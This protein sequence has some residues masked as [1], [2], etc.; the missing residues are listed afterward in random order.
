VTITFDALSPGVLN[1]QYPN[2]V[3]NWGG[4]TWIISGPWGSFT[5]NSL[6]FANAGIFSGSFSF[7]NQ[8][9]LVSIDAYNDDATPAT[10]TL[11]CLGQPNNQVTLDGGQLLTITIGWN[12]ACSPVTIMNSNS[13]HTNFNNLIVD[14]P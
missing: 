11:S 1:G 12:D 8:T 7:V 4:G 3:I 14:S 9:R 2:G 5:N 10:V 6:S 13:W